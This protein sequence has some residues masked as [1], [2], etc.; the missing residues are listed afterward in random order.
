MTTSVY[1]S[2][3]QEVDND[4]FGGEIKKKGD[5]KETTK[6]TKKSTKPVTDD[7]LF[8]DSGSIFDDIPS[9]SKDKKKKK[10]DSGIDIFAK[11]DSGKSCCPS[12]GGGGCVRCLF[13]R[14][15]LF[16]TPDFPPKNYLCHDQFW[17]YWNILNLCQMSQ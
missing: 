17:L 15:V 11:N 7:D 13:L 1:F 16:A 10:P 5:K 2:F 9:K 3:Y 14:K 6:K 12:S 4:L 8:G